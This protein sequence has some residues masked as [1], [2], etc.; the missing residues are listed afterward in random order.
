MIDPLKM[1]QQTLHIR[2]PLV[3][4]V[5]CISGFFKCN[6]PR[7]AVNLGVYS[8]RRDEIADKLLRLTFSQIKELRET[9]HSHACVVLGDD[10]DV[11]LYHSFAQ[12]LPALKGLLIG[13]LISLRIEDVG[14]GKVWPVRLGDHRPSHYFG[15]GELF[16]ELCVWTGLGDA[17][18]SVNA[19]K[20]IG[21]FVI[22]WC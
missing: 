14:A 6:D 17:M 15:D 18:I 11:V 2:A 1:A 21:L 22:V 5:I 13:G 4:H 19:L 9:V 7:R 8:F 20:E 16:E 10:A 3:Q 12:I